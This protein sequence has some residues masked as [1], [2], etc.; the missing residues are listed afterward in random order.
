MGHQW[1]SGICK[2]KEKTACGHRLHGELSRSPV[3]LFHDFK[4]VRISG[5]YGSYT[6]GKN[7][8]ELI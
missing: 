6:L 5:G 4:D 1:T 7:L 8:A 2:E 3:R